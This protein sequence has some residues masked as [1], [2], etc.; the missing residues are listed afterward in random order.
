MKTK[1]IALTA[2]TTLALGGAAFAQDPE[3]NDGGGRRGGRGGG[4]G[5]D[6]IEHKMDALNL[7]AD[8]KT[9]I[10]PIL[11]EAKPKMAEIHRDAMQKS[12]AVMDA[13]MEKIRPMLTP[14]QQTKLDAQK[15]DRRG[16]RE[17]RKGRH[18]GG[19]GAPDD[20]NNG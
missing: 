9:K 11:D 18:H 15:N 8:Q 17:G 12:K 16:N 7:T 20:D 1:L 3:S 5:H 6:P 14:E 13:T 2:F 19:S 10:Q 4:R